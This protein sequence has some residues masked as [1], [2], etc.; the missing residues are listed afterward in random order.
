MHMKKRLLIILTLSVM[1]ASA[2]V[3]CARKPSPDDKVIARVANKTITVGDLKSRIA[4]MPPY[5][6]KIV[7][8]NMRRF[9]DETVIEI[10]LYEEAVRKGLAQDKEVR[11]VINQAKRKIMI[12]M[13]IKTEVED[14]VKVNDDETKK[15][16]DANKDKFL[17]PAMW[18]ASHILVT[19]E[20]EARQIQSEL[21][22]GA[23][24]EELARA[25][26]MDATASRGGDIGY[27]RP[28]QLVPD[29]EKAAL[30]LN[31]GETSDIVHTQ[32]GYHIIKL[33]DRKESAPENYDKA[34][35][36]IES[37]LKAVKRSELF[38]K[39]LS[40]L[41]KKYGA[42]IEEDARGY[43]ETAPKG[44]EASAK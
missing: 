27:F 31:A 13:V 20:S 15:F 24:F 23:S 35:R 2:G 43:L 44:K 6:Q 28:G 18:R 41:K 3:G 29:F 10:L 33:T 42:H 16:Y 25:R 32:F 14:K 4:K 38:D 37:E 8:R 26:S 40:D 9:L 21:A 12:A 1:L 22:K 5:Y 39:V 36:V 30:K 7:E 34:K 19:S 17:A 11:E